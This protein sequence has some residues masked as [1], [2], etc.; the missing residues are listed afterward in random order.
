MYLVVYYFKIQMQ[1][2]K[3]YDI[4]LVPPFDSLEGCLADLE[5]IAKGLSIYDVTHVLRFF[6]SPSPL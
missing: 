3:S 1:N 6:T 4:L 2:E 5:K